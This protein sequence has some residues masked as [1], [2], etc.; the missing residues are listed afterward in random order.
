MKQQDTQDLVRVIEK[1]ILLPHEKK[2]EM[3]LVGRKKVEEEFNRQIVVE[4][5]MNEVNEI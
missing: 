3:G 4:K 2:V 5:Y 1:F